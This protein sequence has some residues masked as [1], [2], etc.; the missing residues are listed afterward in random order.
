MRDC[1]AMR[2]GL[3]M[4]T[5]PLFAS[6]CSIFDYDTTRV[7]LRSAA[8]CST[9]L[10]FLRRRLQ[11]ALEAV[12]DAMEHPFLIMSAAHTCPQISGSSTLDG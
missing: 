5:L 4:N 12:L 1:S 2:Q 7:L 8:S 3:A 9:S 10:V 6:L 11:M